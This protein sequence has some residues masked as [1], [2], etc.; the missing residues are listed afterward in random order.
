MKKIRKANLGMS[1]NDAPLSTWLNPNN[2]FNTVQFGQNPDPSSETKRYTW[3]SDQDWLSWQGPYYDKYL[4]QQIETPS[5][6]NQQKEKVNNSFNGAPLLT[7]LDP[8]DWFNTIQSGQ[9]PDPFSKTE[10]KGYK[11]PK[12]T[13]LPDQNQFSLQG[14]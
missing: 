1:F 11:V 5:P 2:Q 14:P 9:N 8:A 3:L 12:Y 10:F 6:D 4:T 7:Q 13:L